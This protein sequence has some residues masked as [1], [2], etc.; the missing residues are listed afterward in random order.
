VITAVIAGESVANVET[1]DV[2]WSVAV[3]AVVYWLAQVYA[4]TLSERSP[5]SPRPSWRELRVARR[6]DSV[7]LESAAPPILLFVVLDLAGSRSRVGV[8]NR[9]VYATITARFGAVIVLLK[10]VLHERCG[11]TR[12]HGRPGLITVD[13]AALHST[14]RVEIPSNLDPLRTASKPAVSIRRAVRS[15]ASSSSVV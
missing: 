15:A 3:T 1:G 13:E 14:P 2:I 10:T 5:E 6:E 12:S 4:N 8:I 11:P 7:I 9:L